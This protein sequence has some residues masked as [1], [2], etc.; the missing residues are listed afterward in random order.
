MS[1]GYL[2]YYTFILDLR[3]K[4]IEEFGE[5]DYFPPNVFRL[6]RKVRV[7]GSKYGA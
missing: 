2:W 5:R 6:I 7:K 3:V 4:L 1:E